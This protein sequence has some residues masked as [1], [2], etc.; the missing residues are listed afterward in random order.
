[1][2]TTRSYY[3]AGVR[4]A[5][6]VLVAGLAFASPA[7]AAAGAPAAAA[8]PAELK[9]LRKACYGGSVKMKKAPAAMRGS[10]KKWR[11]LGL[12]LVSEAKYADGKRELVRALQIGGDDETSLRALATAL[13]NLGG[14][15]AANACVTLLEKLPPKPK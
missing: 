1:M 9:A 13:S 15:D 2:G 7:P 8:T 6:T 4:M 5:L 12:Q 14:Q 10:V 11:T 3:N